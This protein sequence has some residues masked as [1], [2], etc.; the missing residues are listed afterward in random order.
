MNP[1]ASAAFNPFIVP[2]R[3][4]DPNSLAEYFADLRATPEQTHYNAMAALG[5]LA[6]L[7]AALFSYTAWKARADMKAAPHLIAF[8]EALDLGC[9]KLHFEGSPVE[10]ARGIRRWMK[11]EGKAAIEGCAHL[12]LHVKGLSVL[13]PEIG[14]FRNVK[15]LNLEGNQLTSLPPEIGE[16][17]ALESLVLQQ[18]KLTTLPPEI[19]R[20]TSLKSLILANNQLA[21]LPKEIGKLIHLEVLPMQHN[22]LKALPPEIGG[23]TALWEVD[24]SHNQLTSLPPDIG[25]LTALRTLDLGA[26]RLT[27]IPIE[28]GGLTRLLTLNLEYNQLQSLPAEIGQLVA[29]INLNLTSNNLTS[30]PPEV[31]ELRALRKLDLSS[32]KLTSLPAEIG[33]LANLKKL[34]A[35]GNKLTSLPP[36]IGQCEKLRELYL[37][38]NLLSDLPFELRTLS[39]IRTLDLGHNL[40]AELP[41][42]LRPLFRSLREVS[43]VGNFL[44]AIPASITPFFSELLTQAEREQLELN[45]HLPPTGI[46]SLRIR[47]VPVPI[48]DDTN[49]SPFEEWDS[50]TRTKSPEELHRLMVHAIM[51]AGVKERAQRIEDETNRRGPLLSSMRGT[52]QQG[53][54]ILRQEGAH[55]S[56][57]FFTSVGLGYRLSAWLNSSP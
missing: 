17:T 28:I 50:P 25:Q 36:E 49:V 24:L 38:G 47:P 9:D 55:L 4:I 33:S 44:S 10:Q 18:N 46:H 32:N 11:N 13:P 7:D 34:N 20:L 2:G 53:V 54:Q 43:I 48:F 12:M 42:V 37:W 29:L 8:Y 15:H 51:A 39:R 26:N 56:H 57:V 35:N 16:L 14:L 19:G 1:L 31:G 3:Y 6:V 45:R 30:L 23:L 5:S 40:F 22:K 52:L 21:T 41:P 27:T